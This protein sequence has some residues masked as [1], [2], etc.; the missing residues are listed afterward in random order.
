MNATHDPMPLNNPNG[1]APDQDL[2]GI[3]PREREVKTS[4]RFPAGWTA[5]PKYPVPKEGSDR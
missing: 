4:P 5:V 3:R 1:Q 2:R